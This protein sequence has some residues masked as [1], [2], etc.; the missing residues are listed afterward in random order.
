MRDRPREL[1]HK[2]RLGEDT[3]LE[4][5]AVTFRGDRLQGPRRK[6]LANEI[7]AIANTAGGSLVLGVDDKTREILGI[8][9]DK[10]DLTESVIFEICNDSIEPPVAFHSY[11]TEIFDSAGNAQAVLQIDIPRSLFVH[12]SPD[13]Y[14]RRQG[15]S[16][17]EM[18][19]DALARLFQQ[20]S[21]AR[22]IR[23]EE[24]AVPGT[25]FADLE[26][27]KWKPF[28]GDRVEVPELTLQKLSLLREDENGVER[29]TVAGVLMC[30]PNPERWLP[31]AVITAVR[32]RGIR[33][34]SNYQLDA[35]EIVGPLDRQIEDALLF[36]GRNM[37]VAATKKP[38][39][40]DVPQYSERAIF[41]A[42]VNAIAH[43]DYSIAGSKIRLFMFDDR[44]ELYSPGAL[45][46]TLTVESMELRQSTRNELVASL[47]AKCPLPNHVGNMG[48]TFLMD[49]RGEGVPIIQE[50]SRQLSGRVPTYEI[51]DEAE[52]R[53]T[54]W[55]AKLPSAPTEPMEPTI[56]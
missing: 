20:R 16:K 37:S 7:A 19:G 36:V 56:F 34:D 55:A 52:L 9:R 10:L 5:K 2:I 44:L 8:P 40:T 6:D 22:L 50:E 29:A 33:R 21:Q 3:S 39:R 46:N 13:G 32:Y 4:L 53:L 24:Q 45:P 49:K 48:R 12:K 42:I 15:S 11:R 28:V 27:S 14:F 30:A 26:S 51:F 54:I 25:S 38:E 17:R 31:G 35:Q 43:R 47:L 23:F 41:E 1:L 18:P